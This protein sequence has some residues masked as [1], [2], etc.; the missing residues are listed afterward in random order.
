[1]VVQMIRAQ[2][3]VGVRGGVGLDGVGCGGLG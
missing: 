3:R 2:G 1:M